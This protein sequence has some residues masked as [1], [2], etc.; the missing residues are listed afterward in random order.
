MLWHS[1]KRFVDVAI[2]PPTQFM[3]PSHLF[4]VLAGIA[5]VSFTAHSAVSVTAAG[6]GPLDFATAPV[7]ADFSTIGVGT[8]ATTTTTAALDA[9]IVANT[10]ASAIVTALPNAATQPPTTDALAR[11]STSYFALQTRPTGN[12]YLLLMM[13]MQNN[14]SAD[15]TSFQLTYDFGVPGASTTE[16]SPGHRV[17]FSVTGAAGSWQPVPALSG[18]NVA[19]PGANAT[20]S[21]ISWPA[22]ANAYVIW[23]DDNAATNPDGGYTI[24]NLSISSVATMVQPTTIVITSPTNNQSTVQLADLVVAT[25]TT[26]AITNVSFYVNGIFFTNDTSFPFGGT[27]TVPLALP[28]GN[29]VLTAVATD[30]TGAMVTSPGVTITIGPN[31]PPQIAI[32][33]TF[34]GTVTGLTFLVG[35]PITVQASYMDDDVITNIEWQVDGAISLTNRINNTWTYLNALAGSHSLRGIATD[36]MGQQTISANWNI[37]VTNPPA[38]VYTRLITNGSDWKY[39][40]SATGAQPDE[41][42][43]GLYVHWYDIN[44]SETGWS[45]GLGELGNGDIPNGYSERT[46]IDIG[47]ATARYPSVYFRKTFN[48]VNPAAFPNLVLRLLRDD[49]A[50]VWLNGFPVWTNNMTTVAPDPVHPSTIANT[51]LAAASD[52]GVA[53]QVINLLNLPSNP[54]IS[55][56]ANVIGVQV[57]NQN[58]TSSDLSFDLMLWG[59]ANVSPLVVITSP[60][61]GASFVECTSVAIAANASTFVT[62]VNFYVDGVLVGSDGSPPFTATYSNAVTGSRQLTAVGTDTFGATIPSVP[63]TIQITPNAL[64]SIAITNVFSVNPGNVFLVGSAITN[65]YSFSDDVGVAAVEF[66]IDG[67]LHYRD[68]AGFG[69]VIANDAAAGLHTYTVVAYDQCNRSSSSTVMVTVTNPPYALL[70]TNQSVWKYNDDGLTQDVSWVTLAF[71]DAGWSNGL[72]E[73]GFGDQPGEDNPERT[74]I[75]RLSGL[76]DTNSVVYYFRKIINVPAPAAYTNLVLSVLRDD[77]AQ[78][79]INGVTVFSTSENG[80]FPP[81][82]AAADD[83]TR[84]VRTNVTPAV[85]VTGPNIVAVEVRQNNAGSS[86]LSFDLMLWGQSASGPALIITPNGNGTYS[87]TWNDPSG[88]YQLQ[89]SGNIASP[90]NWGDVP[91]NPPSGYTQPFGAANPLFYRLRKP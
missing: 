88:L 89:R 30:N 8:A 16:T 57:H 59:E 47:P 27:V 40:A 42:I 2:K 61:N 52:D 49:G 38:A 62:N 55:A 86:D 24:D 76:L 68:T 63:V 6:G 22:G 45:T 58:A 78:V 77:G 11:H 26:G 53:Y 90:L 69:E 70:L 32:T 12:D 79:H 41:L 23:A 60:T 9:A 21:G 51:N 56:G 35:S 74:V 14:A 5:G 25:M 20:I 39:F 34:S 17:F 18:L 75:R 10:V 19:T 33:N 73:L 83:G 1:R 31:L 65:Q 29:Y 46:L 66:Y 80:A 85:L 72:A 50:V 82:A 28:L 36:R 13:T 64:P 15:I 7:A 91:G 3:K 87:I 71:N 44:Y 48:V 67:T 43:P 84:Y 54:I 81:T 4:L 37:T